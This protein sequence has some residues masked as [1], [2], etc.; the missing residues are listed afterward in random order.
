M[1]KLNAYFQIK[2]KNHIRKYIKGWHKRVV[3]IDINFKSH[4]TRFLVSKNCMIDLV[5]FTKCSHI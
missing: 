5:S 2:K 1:N 4:A 3:I